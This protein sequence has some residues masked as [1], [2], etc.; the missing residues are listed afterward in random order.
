MEEEKEGY[1]VTRYPQS[2]GYRRTEKG[3]ERNNKITAT[4]TLCQAK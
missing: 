2:L 3:V 4:A 1:M